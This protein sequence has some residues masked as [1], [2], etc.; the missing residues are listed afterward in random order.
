[1][2]ATPAHLVG[3][4]VSRNTAYASKVTSANPMDDDGST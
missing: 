2:T 3:V 1:M 4:T